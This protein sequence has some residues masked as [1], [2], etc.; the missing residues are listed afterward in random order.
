MAISL[1]MVLSEE[2]NVWERSDHILVNHLPEL[3]VH[4]KLVPWALW[5]G[6]REG[7]VREE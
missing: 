7:G 4:K 1:D 2:L 3:S 5:R 6:V